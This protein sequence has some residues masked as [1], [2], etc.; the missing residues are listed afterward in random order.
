MS[1]CGGKG[2]VKENLR[3]GLFTY[4]HLTS[5][6][7]CGGSGEE[8]T[9][10]CKK[11]NGSGKVSETKEFNITIPKGSKTGDIIKI[12]N[13]GEMGSTLLLLLTVNDEEKNFKRQGDDLLTN[14]TITMKDALLGFKK[15]IPHLDGH[16]IFIE[17]NG[18]TSDGQ[19]IR[20]KGEGLKKNFLFNGDC[21]ISIHV[22]MNSISHDQALK[23]AK[24]LNQTN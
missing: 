16:Q 14:L 18:V 15:Q 4:E 6:P 2:V 5:C 9:E 24:I 3:L 23:I 1:K 20:I 13:M 17:Q 21:L 7:I 12:K 10:K 8:I 22:D 19:V 11:C